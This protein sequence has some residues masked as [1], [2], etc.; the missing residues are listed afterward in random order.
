ML[1]RGSNGGCR[2][3]AERC[4]ILSTVGFGPIALIALLRREGRRAVVRH[5][6]CELLLSRR[7]EMHRIDP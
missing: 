7:H 1:R 6:I 3:A 5:E 2:E 4:T